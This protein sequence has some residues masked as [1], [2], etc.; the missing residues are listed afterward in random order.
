VGAHSC[1]GAAAPRDEEVRGQLGVSAAAADTARVP[2]PRVQ[3]LQ[4]KRDFSRHAGEARLYLGLRCG[5][6][7]LRT[8][9]KWAFGRQWVALVCRERTCTQGASADRCSSVAS[10]K[11]SEAGSGCGAETGTWAGRVLQRRA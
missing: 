4:P 7:Q 2:Q 6:S 1:L 9:N 11:R 8:L 5:T 10:A 3:A